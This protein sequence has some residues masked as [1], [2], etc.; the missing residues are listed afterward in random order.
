MSAADLASLADG[1]LYADLEQTYVRGL[2]FSHV[3]ALATREVVQRMKEHLYE[4]GASLKLRL[5]PP[6]GEVDNRGRARPPMRLV[7]ADRDVRFR[8]SLAVHEQALIVSDRV[9][10]TAGRGDSIQKIAAA[11]VK[12][13]K[14]SLG[15]SE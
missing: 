6:T 14:H 10:A 1:A 12:A 11:I 8:I 15:T 7:V 9:I 13:M 4:T 5:E 2:N 3:V